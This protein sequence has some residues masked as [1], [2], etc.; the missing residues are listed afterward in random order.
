MFICLNVIMNIIIPKSSAPSSR[1]AAGGPP[2]RGPAPWPG[3]I[4]HETRLD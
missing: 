3:M 2:P 4:P 1:T